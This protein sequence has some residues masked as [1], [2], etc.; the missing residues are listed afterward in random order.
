MKK[1]VDKNKQNNYKVPDFGMCCWNFL[2]IGCYD[3]LSF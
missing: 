3:S 2:F 1:L